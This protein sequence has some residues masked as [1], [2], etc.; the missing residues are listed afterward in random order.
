MRLK[1]SPQ[2]SNSEKPIRVGNAKTRV[3]AIKSHINKLFVDDVD[4]L[5]C[6]EVN[7]L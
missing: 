4:T 3:L 6:R 5:R 1:E 2:L 7:K